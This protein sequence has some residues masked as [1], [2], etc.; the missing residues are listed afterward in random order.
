MISNNLLTLLHESGI[1]IR[2][3]T[4]VK[5]IL[6]NKTILSWILKFTVKEFKDN[7]IEEIW[8]C[9]EGE[10][11]ISETPLRPRHPPECISGISNEDKEITEGFISY[12]IIFHA[13]TPIKERTKI[14]INVEAQNNYY[15][16]YDLVTRGIFYGARMISSQLDREFTTDNYDNIK[17]VYS[18][19]ICMDTPNYAQHTITEYKITPE[20]IWGNFSGKARYDLLSVVMICLG[21]SFDSNNQLISMLNTILSEKISATEKESILATEYGIRM[22]TDEDGGVNLMCNLSDRIEQIGIKKGIEQ[23][24]EQGTLKTLFELYH[25]NL[26]SLQD[27]AHKASLTEE[28]FLDATKNFM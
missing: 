5:K 17:K 23:G 8:E 24:I 1:K 22:K 11:Q 15:P 21:D 2:Y 12:D 20:K 10:P 6:S 18:I 25:D 7:T 16:G 26:I 28:S 9:I 14:I 4:E 13:L 3:D 19:W 27:A